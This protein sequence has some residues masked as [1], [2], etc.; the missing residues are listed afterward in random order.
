MQGRQDSNR[1]A[2]KRAISQQ[3]HFMNNDSGKQRGIPKR[4]PTMAHIDQPPP[5]A[6]V[7]RPQRNNRQ[8]ASCRRRMITWG[9]VS[10]VCVVLAFIL[11]YAA[12]NFFAATNATADAAVTATDFLSS[13]S[14]QNYDHAYND[15]GPAI[16]IP[17]TQDDFKQQAQDDDRCYGPV[18]DYSEVANSAVQNNPQSYTYSFNI[19]RSKLPHPYTLRMT[20]QQDSTTGHWQISS[21]GNNNDLGPGQPPCS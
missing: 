6:R 1:E 21:Y 3:F 20:L 4:P 11:G 5:T 10:V 17:V 12:I 16:T 15:L 13:L 14:S 19:T 9:I 2:Q 18:T 8:P 7:A